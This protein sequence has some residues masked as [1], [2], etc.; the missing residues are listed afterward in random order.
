MIAWIA[1]RIRVLT[2]NVWALPFGIA[3]LEAERITAIGKALPEY[4]ADLVAFQE[5]WTEGS[6]ARLLAAGASA[7]YRHH[8]MRPQARGGSGL[9]VLSRFPIEAAHFQSFRVEGDALRLDHSDYY[10]GKGFVI[11]RVATPD[12]P[13]AFADTHLHARY[14]KDT[15][16]D[17]YFE[18]RVAQVVQ[19]ATA[20]R[21]VAAPLI[22]AG[23]FNFREG[24]AEYAIW[25]GIGGSGDA[26]ALLDRRE[27][28]IHAGN[29][30]RAV[31]SWVENER[32]DYLFSRDGAD[33]GV[34]PVTVRRAFDEVQ[35][36]GGEPSSASDHA[37][38]FAE[39]EVGGR[40]KPQTPPDPASL[41]QARAILET[42]LDQARA[43]Q[44]IEGGAAI[45]TLALAVGAAKTSARV[46]R[47]RWLQGAAGALASCATGFGWLAWRPSGERIAGFEAGLAEVD[48]FAAQEAPR[49]PH[50]E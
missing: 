48:A 16:S 13:L 36:I 38:V 1:V 31:G 17:S 10:G 6:R 15:Q 30:Y 44:K 22:A 2:L 41:E 20:I 23:D 18:T 5:A 42:G 43:R 37:G 14:A 11:L 7:G 35:N 49:R 26:A 12:G 9:L 24:E 28:T 32:I 21:T 27:A 47:R 34:V 40:A 45:A 3:P 29:T 50:R 19:F 39:F 25:T 46:S 33:R 8:W 4:D